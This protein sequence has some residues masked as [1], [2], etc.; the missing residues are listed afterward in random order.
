MPSPETEQQLALQH[1]IARLIADASADR[2]VVSVAK[3]ANRLAHQY[4]SSGLSSNAI[5]KIIVS[6][7]KPVGIALELDD[8]PTSR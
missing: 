3:Q 4:S 6:L 5:A 2:V 1:E 7:A 8:L